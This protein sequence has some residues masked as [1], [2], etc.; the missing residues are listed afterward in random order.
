MDS[1]PTTLSYLDRGFEIR[2]WFNHYE[3]C[4]N[5]DMEQGFD[6]QEA[7]DDAAMRKDV[8]EN[9]RFIIIDD[10][11]DMEPYMDRLVQTDARHGLMWKDADKAIEMLGGK[12]G[13]DGS[14]GREHNDDA[15]R[16]QEGAGPDGR[17]EPGTVHSSGDGGGSEESPEDSR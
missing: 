9:K 11:S 5:P 7:E 12:D 14:V 3:D 13:K 17:S 4:E 16:A 2:R 10:D 1:T 6:S 8:L 15:G